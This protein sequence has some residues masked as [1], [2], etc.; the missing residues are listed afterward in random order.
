MNVVRL[1]LAFA[2]IAIALKTGLVAY[3]AVQHIGANME[4]RLAQ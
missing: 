4:V 3:A 2:F 1:I